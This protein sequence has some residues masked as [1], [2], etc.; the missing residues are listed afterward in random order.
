MA[1]S[2][3][4]ISNDSKV[5]LHFSLSLADNRVIDSNFE[6]D[7]VRF[8]IGDGSMLPEFEKLLLGKQEGSLVES[9]ILAAKAFGERNPKNVQRFPIDKFSH[10]LEDETMPTEIG[11]VVMFKDPAGFDLPGVV[12]EISEEFV[13]MDFNHPLSGKNITFKA[14]IIKIDEPG[15]AEIEVKL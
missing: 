6:K 10:L 13:V 3:K 9:T 2:E 15:V 12:S 4:K 1:V 5:T 8:R 14:R 7:P 11:S